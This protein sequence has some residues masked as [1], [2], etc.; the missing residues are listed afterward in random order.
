MP[1]GGPGPGSGNGWAADEKH[2]GQNNQKTIG[3][4]GNFG[5]PRCITNFQAWCRILSV[6]FSSFSS[7]GA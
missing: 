5:I 4:L 1:I 6:M 7:P 3:I 2:D